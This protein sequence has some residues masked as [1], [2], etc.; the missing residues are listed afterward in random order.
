MKV[1]SKSNKKDKIDKEK[2]VEKKKKKKK[3][4]Q[5]K[6]TKKE[7]LINSKRNELS[8]NDNEVKYGDCIFYELPLRLL[9]LFVFLHLYSN[10][11][12]LVVTR[13]ARLKKV[14]LTRVLGILDSVFG[15]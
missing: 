9:L 12:D 13:K 6:R 8:D 4:H 2:K 1:A 11:V 14:S 7:T 5:N 15:I 10:I 3:K